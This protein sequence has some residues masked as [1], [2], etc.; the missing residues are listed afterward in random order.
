MWWARCLGARGNTESFFWRVACT[1]CRGTWRHQSPFLAGGALF[2]MGHMVTPEPS[3]SG[4]RALCLGAHQPSPLPSS[5]DHAGATCYRRWAP[6]CHAAHHW[7]SVRISSLCLPLACAAEGLCLHPLC[8]LHAIPLRLATDFSAATTTPSVT[9]SFPAILSG[10]WC[11]G[12]RVETHGPFLRRQF[13][14]FTVV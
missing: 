14:E 2:A 13:Q 4:W 11:S 12:A 9:N 1:V 8:P 5:S 3:S 7:P 6:P 10:S